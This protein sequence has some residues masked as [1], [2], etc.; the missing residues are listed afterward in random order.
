MR[1]SVRV[2]LAGWNKEGLP[3]LEARCEELNLQLHHGESGGQ[4]GITYD[5]SYK[6]GDSEVELVQGMIDAVN[7]LYKEDL[8]LQKQHRL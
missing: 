3:D 7:R 2:D 8:E 6:L 5:I 4:T 1:A